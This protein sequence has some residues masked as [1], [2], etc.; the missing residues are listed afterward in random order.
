MMVNITHIKHFLIGTTLKDSLQAE[1]SMYSDSK[2][3]ERNYWKNEYQT[4][5]C[6]NGR[7]SVRV[8]M[9]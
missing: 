8:I 6:D 3:A 9:T 7:H 1:H 4:S 2:I 5:D